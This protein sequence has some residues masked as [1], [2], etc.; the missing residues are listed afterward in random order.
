MCRVQPGS[1]LRPAVRPAPDI[2]IVDDELLLG[3]SLEEALEQAGYWAACARTGSEALAMLDRLARPALILL[4]LQ[5]PLMDGLKFLEELRKRPDR[6]DFE[7][8]AMS[9]A[10]HGEWLEHT[11][12]VRRTLRKP[13]D[14]QELL[15]EVKSFEARH[16][17]PAGS[18][19]AATDQTT[20]LGP[21]TKAASPEAD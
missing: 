16:T 1:T 2:L 4:D 7:V 17:V 12:E 20:V 14:V 15:S 11:R 19:T 5:M 6:A 10:V 3:E 9:A 21:E 18:V 13:F 8:L